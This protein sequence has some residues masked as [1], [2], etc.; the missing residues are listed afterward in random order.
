MRG[1][2]SISV[3]T[4]MGLARYFG[5]TAAIWLRLQ[6]QYDIEVA[7]TN[8]AERINR[9]VKILDQDSL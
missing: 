6:S 5:T 2:R 9:E 1:K 7:E 4:A 3:D 8:F